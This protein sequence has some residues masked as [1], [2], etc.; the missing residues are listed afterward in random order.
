ML[1]HET[2]GQTGR[3]KYLETRSDNQINT[4]RKMTNKSLSMKTWE[5]KA[6]QRGDINES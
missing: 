3:G 2:Q 5:I 4:G 6:V 1:S